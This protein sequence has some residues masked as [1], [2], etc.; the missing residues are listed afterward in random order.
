MRFSSHCCCSRCSAGGFIPSAGSAPHSARRC[1]WFPVAQP[2]YL[3]WA[4]I[5]LATWATRRGFRT[6]AITLT[7]VIGI[8]GPTANGD[9]FAIF[10]IV[11]ATLA[12]VVIV[13]MLVAITY[14]RLPWRALPEPD[15]AD[16]GPPD[17]PTTSPQAGRLR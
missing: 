5:P 10:Q 1:C 3:L 12:S 13:I 4:I 8:F 11:D 15:D 14:N 16:P 6:T 17:V 7:L 2:W 9:R